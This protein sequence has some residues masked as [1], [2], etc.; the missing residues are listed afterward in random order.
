V[1]CPRPVPSPRALVP[2]PRSVP[3]FRGDYSAICCHTG[4]AQPRI[5]EQSGSHPG[6]AT[7]QRQGAVAR[8]RS[9]P[10]K[11]GNHSRS[12]PASITALREVR[13]ARRQ[14]P[15]GSATPSATRTRARARAHAHAH[16]AELFGYSRP[17]GAYTATNN[18]TVRFSSREGDTP[19]QGAA[20][21][22]RRRPPKR[23][24]HSRSGPASITALREVR[25]ARR[26]VPAGSATPSATRTRA[27]AHAHAAELFGYSRPYRARAA[28]NTRTVRF[29][30]RRND[31]P[32]QGAVARQR[33][34]PPKRGNH[35]RSGPA[36]AT[37]L[38]A[39]G[40]RRFPVGARR[41]PHAA[42]HAH[43]HVFA[44]VV[45]ALTAGLFGYSWPYRARV[46]ANT[47]TVRFP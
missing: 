10:P 28:A 27:H 24:N 34:R 23:G 29:P 26:Q 20:A 22:Q 13:H 1:P 6:S 19:A 36:S 35:D 18:R 3:S 8:Q 9:R 17:Y 30:S 25:H 16:A 44:H 45:D 32:A 31:T 38:R 47:R 39:V 40:R 5:P 7:L 21:R 41:R 4:R 42:A 43:V 37:A 2:Y 15:A 46:G 14:V 33:R 12:G 11:C